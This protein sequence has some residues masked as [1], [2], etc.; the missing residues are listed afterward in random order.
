VESPLAEAH[1]EIKHLEHVAESRLKI[2]LTVSILVVTML[3]TLG[4]V[5]AAIWSAKHSEAQ[6]ARQQATA[7]S[8]QASLDATAQQATV[9]QALDDVTE[10]AWRS[11]FLNV[12]S[13]EVG[14]DTLATALRTQAGEATKVQQAEAASLPSGANGPSY[15]AKLRQPAMV[16]E[17]VAK[18]HAQESVGWLAKNNSALAV[19]SML[20][21][22]LFLLGLA[23]TISNRPTQ[24]GFTI[25]AIVMTVIAGA[26]LAQV[27]AKPIVVASESCIDRYGDAVTDANGGDMKAA[28]TAL[29]AVVGDCSHFEA[30]WTALGEVRFRGTGADSR[31][32]AQDAFQRALDV[33]DAK[34]TELY[35]N[36]GYVQTLNKQYDAAQVN[37]DKAAE[38]SPDNPIVMSSRAELAVARGDSTTADK[39]LDEALSSV[40]KHGPYFRDEFYFAN[41]RSD[42]ADFTEAGLTSHAIGQFFLRGREAE[43]SIGAL[44]AITPGDTHGA[45]ITGLIL[46]KSATKLGSIADFVTIG[47]TYHG[48]QV[49]DHI[50]VRF[51]ANGLTYDLTASLPDAVV[52]SNSTLVGSGIEPPDSHFRLGLS[53]KGETTMEVYLNGVSQGEV[54]ITI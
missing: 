6:R 44:G 8:L 4:G 12:N 47:F 38:L 29:S 28:T 13:L 31:Q 18:A 35:N 26:R 11:A 49:G 9:D 20:A 51:Y 52:Q 2:I 3:A 36:L 42:E 5:M 30:A 48:L 23:L 50:S 16:D 45:R 41:L 15:A 43:A 46:R 22:A 34:S 14:N 10:A 21:L 1:E 19:V 39:Y 53:N 24:T 37:L 17:E 54:S 25:L 33:A 40:S 7:A 27:A 32:S